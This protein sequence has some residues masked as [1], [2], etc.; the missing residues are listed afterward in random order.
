MRRL[1]IIIAICLMAPL[2][3]GTSRTR[4]VYP[5]ESRKYTLIDYDGL[6]VSSAW[7]IDANDNWMPVTGAF[8]D[9][10]FE[11]DVDNDIMVTQYIYF[12]LDTNN[13]LILPLLGDGTVDLSA[14]NLTTTGAISS[15]ALTVTTGAYDALDVS[16]INVIFLDCSGGAITIGGFVG[17]VRGQ[18]LYIA[19]LCASAANLTLEHVESTGNQDIY[20]HAGSD[21]TLFTEYGGWVLICNGTSWFDTSHAKHV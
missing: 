11:V 12:G 20:L 6:I 2:C 19:R 17:G 4:I 18:V 16:G 14:E 5:V 7:E 21:E 3:V 1:T 15:G 8:N 9:P 13:D 10:Y